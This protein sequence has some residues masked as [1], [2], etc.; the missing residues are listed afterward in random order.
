MP[1]I[2]LLGR[3]YKYMLIIIIALAALILSY[4]FL[5]PFIKTPQQQRKFFKRFLIITP[6]AVIGY[7]VIFYF[8]EYNKPE[9]FRTSIELLEQRQDVKNKIGSYESYS[10]FR[11][12]LPLNT[13]NP[14]R[15]KLSMK[16]SDAT[17]YITCEARKN[18]KGEWYIS[19]IKQDSLVK[20]KQIPF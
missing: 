15:F 13:D 19:K 17:I 18:K 11:K 7:W 4:F 20:T 5:K 16:G 9:S 1:V 12:D 3:I 8:T 10:Y 14:A 6:V 2:W